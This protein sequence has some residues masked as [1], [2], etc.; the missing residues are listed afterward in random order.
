[1]PNLTTSERIGTVV[2]GRYEVR[3]LLGEG[4]FSSVFAA[5]HNVTGREVALKLLHPHLVT[6]EQIT[7][8]FL[9]EAR[10]MAKINHDGIVQVLDAGRDPDGTVFIAL[11]LLNG[12]S[13]EATLDRV[14]RITWGEAVSIGVDILNA[15]AE[16][17][18]HQVIHRDIKPGNIFV[19]RKADG[20]SQ[21]KL[22]DFGI[23]H[24]AQAKGR[25]TQTGTILGTPEY[26]SPEQGRGVSIGPEADLWSVGVVLFECL[27]GTT[28]FAAETTTDILVKVATEKAPSLLSMGV[29]VPGG[30]ARAID[31]ALERDLAVRYRSADE[32]REALQHAVSRVDARRREPTP[33]RGSP[34][35]ASRPLVEA[36]SGGL[37]VQLGP[38]QRPAEERTSGVAVSVAP[39]R[40]RSQPSFNLDDI[41]STGTG[42]KSA[43][44]AQRPA[45]PLTPDNG[46]DPLWMPEPLGSPARREVTPREATPHSPPPR[47]LTPRD[48][49]PRAAPGR[50]SISRVDESTSVGRR[51]SLPETP[52]PT[53]VEVG[54]RPSM[55]GFQAP[56]PEEPSARR[57]LLI[58]GGVVAA[59]GLALALA[60]GLGG[61]DSQDNPR[62]PV[63]G[64]AVVTSP[65]PHHP[66]TTPA[67]V[68][69]LPFQD[70]HAVGLPAGISGMDSAADFAR[71]AVAS[72]TVG[73]TQRIIATCLP[74]VEGGTTVFVHPLAQGPI[75]SS[76][77]ARV[78]CQG[79][80]L[81]VVGDLTNDGTDDILAVSEG[82]GALLVLDAR[83]LQPW[84]TLR[85]PGALG[86][87]S[88]S[89]IP[90]Q[91]DVAA[92]VYS[93]PEGV[94]RPTEV[95]AIGLRS[96]RVL[97]RIQ[98]AEG[99]GRVGQPVEL[100]LAVGPDANGDGVFDVVMGLGP[101]IGAAPPAGG[102][103]RC[104]QAFSGATGQ[105]LWPAQCQAG[106]RSA[107]SVALGP[108]V[109]GDG[110]GDVVVGTDQPPT[111]EPAVRLLSGANG[112]LLRALTAP[113]EDASAG[114]GWPVALSGNMLVQGAPHVVVGSVG[115][116]TMVT[117][118]D[119]RTGATVG[120][121]AL[122]GAGA[123]NLRL[124]PI[125]PVVPSQPWSLLVANPA[126]G[127]HVWAAE[128]AAR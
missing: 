103:R 40:S 63:A 55:T 80:D 94:G 125:A 106:G 85:L 7:E 105:P 45:G 48:S 116:T 39:A 64:P 79:H 20:G 22:L 14:G 4:G 46:L 53:T 78:A 111:G 68:A 112:S 100:G 88:G 9:M 104:V 107:Q 23:A 16:A 74:R 49:S 5:M 26:M 3:R 1:M 31:K 90:T 84:R 81:G 96:Q 97:W 47:E 12:E 58:G 117:V 15:L 42:R 102:P 65:D 69:A 113:D 38:P 108:D 128:A 13:L 51:G 10:A 99:L 121:R 52:R 127:L 28:P 93:E 66:P 70:V 18:R 109:D 57:N 101:V 110:R 83:T 6:T 59:L 92:V 56:P 60:R 120:R 77:R 115:V 30:V 87:A 29:E 82:G 44:S 67:P 2:G 41:P 76:A 19:V 89:V 98:G 50:G 43:A 27:T 123:G 54:E 119:A 11:E 122:G 61:S 34:L 73:V 95:V 8:R 62:A 75:L 91:D 32:M 25:M 24:V 118:L 33:P 36:T 17:H 21:A 37:A 71:H 126:D 86:L 114:F 72:P 124:F 35:L